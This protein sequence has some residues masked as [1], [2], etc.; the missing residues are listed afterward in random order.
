MEN[1]LYRVEYLD[2]LE[3]TVMIPW[4]LDQ[5]K[6]AK[7]VPISTRPGR[8]TATPFGVFIQ[9]VFESDYRLALNYYGLIK[10]STAQMRQNMYC[11]RQFKVKAVMV[12]F[13]SLKIEHI[14][15]YN[16]E[17]LPDFVKFKNFLVDLRWRS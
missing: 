2:Q 17:L 5:F 4:Y 14:E 7:P 11:R 9:S 15:K 16:P 6:D 1:K 3:Q 12:H 10:V 13:N 8:L